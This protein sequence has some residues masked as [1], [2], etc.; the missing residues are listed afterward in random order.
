MEE[1]VVISLVQAL[2]TYL[3]NRSKADLSA[4]M[5]QALA[6]NH[7]EQVRIGVAVT[8]PSSPSV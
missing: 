5:Q 3:S 4:E 8:P 2:T 7:A 1:Q 6:A